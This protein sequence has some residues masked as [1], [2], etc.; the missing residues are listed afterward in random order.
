ML[1]AHVEAG[2]PSP[3]EDFVEGRLDLNAYLIHRPA[4]TFLL[5]VSG[6]SMKGAGLYPGDVVTVDRSLAPRN[7]SIVIAALNGELTVK[8]LRWTAGGGVLKAANPAFPDFPLGEDVE[9][10]IWGVVTGLVRRIDGR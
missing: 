5:R 6:E 8:T 10:V 7:G 9:T 2:F 3:A 4:A 1:G